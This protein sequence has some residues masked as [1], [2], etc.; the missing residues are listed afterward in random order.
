MQ[1]S[2]RL[3]HPKRIRRNPGTEPFHAGRKLVY[4][5]PEENLNEKNIE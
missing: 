2:H 1:I 3:I 5:F 4:C